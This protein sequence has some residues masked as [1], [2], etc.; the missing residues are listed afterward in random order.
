MRNH[1]KEK[2]K[3]YFRSEKEWYLKEYKISQPSNE[4]GLIYDVIQVNNS[5]T[6]QYKNYQIAVKENIINSV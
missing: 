6:N 5:G 3:N 1:H 4:C 2:D